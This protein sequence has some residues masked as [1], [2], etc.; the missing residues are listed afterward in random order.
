MMRNSVLLV[1]AI[2]LVASLLIANQ[3]TNATMQ[4]QDKTRPA[5]TKHLMGGIIAPQSKALGAALKEGPADDKAWAAVAMNAALLNEI[6]YNLMEDDRCPDEV[7]AD[8]VQVLRDQSAEVMAMTEAK[9]AAAASE[10]FS[11][12]TESCKSCHKAHKK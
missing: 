10:A 8:A 1:V 3:Q 12:L 2:T 7:W 5:K 6:S 11:G 4:Q 9:D